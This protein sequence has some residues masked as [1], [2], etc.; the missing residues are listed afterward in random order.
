[1]V[2]IKNFHANLLIIDK[3]SYEEI[4]VYNIG[5]IAIKKFGSCKNINS[6]NPVSLIIYSATEYFKEKYDEKYLILDPTNKYE[7]VFSGIRSKIE[8]LND[9]K[10]T[11]LLKK[12]C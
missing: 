6:V 12:L 5:Y 9:R 4:D 7:E 3:K 8:T 11:V 1:M 10:K 2:N